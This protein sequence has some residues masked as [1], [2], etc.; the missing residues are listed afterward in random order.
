L[1]ALSMGNPVS[2]RPRNRPRSPTVVVNTSASGSDGVAGGPGLPSEGGRT[3]CHQQFLSH[4][5]S[6][7][8]VSLSG[9]R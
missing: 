2:F 3:R 5:P 6:Q 8:S 1:N 9:R 4:S 7:W